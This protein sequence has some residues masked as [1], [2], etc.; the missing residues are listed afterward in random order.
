VGFVVHFVARA[1][2]KQTLV[3]EKGTVSYYES[4]E[5]EDTP[6]H[7][8]RTDGLNS[9]AGMSTDELILY[10]IDYFHRSLEKR[11]EMGARTALWTNRVIKSGMAGLML[12]AASILVLVFVVSKQMSDIALVTTKMDTQMAQMVTDIR[13]MSTYVNSIGDSVSTLPIIVEEISNMERN[14]SEMGDYVSQVSETMTHTD[15][16]VEQMVVNIDEM[17]SNLSNVT[18]IVRGMDQSIDRVSRPFR[19]FNKMIP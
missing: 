6:Y 15:Q 10:S 14:V 7:K 8:R 4:E 9:T 3:Q 5:H 19:I 12:I 13:E 11:G 18:L 2:M 1:G 17:E 16:V